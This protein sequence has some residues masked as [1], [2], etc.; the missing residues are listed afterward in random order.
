MMMWGNV[1]VVGCIYKTSLFKN[2][3]K[4]RRKIKMKK[5][6]SVIL[7]FLLI[8]P[9]LSQIPVSA[10][11]NIDVILNGQLITFPD[12]QPKIINNRTLVPVRSI[13]EALGGNVEWDQKTQTAI[14]QRGLNTAVF[15]IG[16]NKAYSKKIKSLDVDAKIIDGRTYIPLRAVSEIFDARVEWDGSKNRI[17]ISCDELTDKKIIDQFYTQGFFYFVHYYS[18]FQSNQN[19]LFYSFAKVLSDIDGFGEKIAIGGIENMVQLVG[20]GDFSSLLNN[21]LKDYNK[22]VLKKN[23]EKILENI[24]ENNMVDTPINETVKTFLS[25]L[26]K[27]VKFEKKEFEAKAKKALNTEYF[28]R[29]EKLSAIGE[30]LGN[31]KWAGYTS[32]A[33][34][35]FLNDYTTNALYLEILKNATNDS[36][37]KKAIS[38]LETLYTKKAA[39]AFIKICDELKKE[40]GGEIL[41]LVPMY[42]IATFL[43]DITTEL[44][45]V[46]KYAENVENATAIMNITFDLMFYYSDLFNNC[47][48]WKNKELKSS[49]TQE[50]WSDVV[51]AFVISKAGLIEAYRCMEAITKDSAEKIY[52]NKQIELI[53]SIKINQNLPDSN[54]EMFYLGDISKD[55]KQELCCNQWISNGVSAGTLQMF[56]F[57]EDGTYITATYGSNEPIGNYKLENNK[58]YLDGPWDNGDILEYNQKTNQWISTTVEVSISREYIDRNGNLKV[59]TEKKTLS[60]I[61]NEERYDWRSK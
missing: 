43:T 39:G 53:E 42:S 31:F 4:E 35:Y 2:E 24:P 7:T 57:F 15:Q 10:S 32:E 47:Y 41:N 9:I 11:S 17:T 21:P 16:K 44:T 46:R 30:A 56:E 48:D 23:V 29:I 6:I 28:E 59:D 51:N 13:A 61:P 45:G 34:E 54:D 55:I 37:L 19:D 52:L 3:I 33:L 40:A 8:L 14:I 20:T 38:E 26:K 5:F 58:L 25:Y 60:K 50:Q 18:E 36:D 49:T 12:A 27:G 1:Y 22:D